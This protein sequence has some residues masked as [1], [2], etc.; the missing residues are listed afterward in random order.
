M[1]HHSVTIPTMECSVH[2]ST[3][4][5]YR[6]SKATSSH[7]GSHFPMLFPRHFRCLHVR[8][9]PS[10]VLYRRRTRR[11]RSPISL[12]LCCDGH[13]RS[14]GRAVWEDRFQLRQCGRVN[15]NRGHIS[16]SRSSDQQTIGG[17][18]VMPSVHSN[19][20]FFGRIFPPMF[21][22]RGVLHVHRFPT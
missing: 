13:V 10:I 1:I 6:P 18:G 2:L 5:L 4:K 22:L 12:P 9:D 16:H 17:R 11:I 3:R 8:Y 21:I 20:R 14:K 15:N 7:K 19:D